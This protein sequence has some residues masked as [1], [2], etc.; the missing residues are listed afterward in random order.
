M[1]A[2]YHPFVIND[3]VINDNVID[4]IIIIVI[5]WLIHTAVAL[6]P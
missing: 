1:I 2:C 6:R 5:E 4:N 3:N